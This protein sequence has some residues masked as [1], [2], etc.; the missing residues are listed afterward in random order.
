MHFLRLWLPTSGHGTDSESLP[1]LTAL[2]D[3]L[4]D[5]RQLKEVCFLYHGLIP[6]NE[7]LEK[8]REVFSPTIPSGII[9]V[10]QGR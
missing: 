7:V 5:L 8:V 1:N 10:A 9:R 3:T 2:V 4:R 6:K